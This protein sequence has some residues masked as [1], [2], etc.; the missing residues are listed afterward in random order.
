[1]NENVYEVLVWKTSVNQNK[2]FEFIYSQEL[3]II[4]WALKQNLMK[5]LKLLFLN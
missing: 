5:L 2:H 3:I 4:G 1:M